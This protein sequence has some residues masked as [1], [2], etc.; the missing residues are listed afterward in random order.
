[1]RNILVV[2][3]EPLVRL[4]LKSISRWEE[5]GYTIK[6]EAENGKEALEIL[7]VEEIDIIICDINMPI[8][9]GLELIQEIKS[10]NLCDKIIVLSAY[11]EYNYLRAAF[12]LGVSDYILKNDMDFNHIVQILNG[13]FTNETDSKAVRDII[14]SKELHEKEY[15][16]ACLIKNEL[17]NINEN[18][19]NLLNLKSNNIILLNIIIEDF[20]SIEKK[21]R[22][23]GLDAFAYS[24]KNCLNQVLSKISYK[25]IV[26]LSPENYVI[27]ISFQSLSLGEIR[28][29][30]IQLISE[31]RYAMK[32]YINLYVSVVVSDIANKFSTIHKLFLECQEASYLRFIYEKDRTIFP[33]DR[34]IISMEGG[35]INYHKEKL[36][37]Q[38]NSMKFQDAMIT[39]NVLLSEA[40]LYLE[41]KT[42]EGIMPLY[43]QIIIVIIDFTYKQ[44]ESIASIFGIDVDFKEV[45]SR[46]KT[47]EEVTIWFNNMMQWLINYF[48][49]KNNINNNMDIIEDKIQSVC[50]FI[51]ENFKEELTLKIVSDYVGLSETYFSKIFTKKVGKSFIA[52]LTHVRVE[53]AK[54]LLKSSGLKIHEISEKVGFINV[55]HFSRVFKKVTGYSPNSFRDE[56]KS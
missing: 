45:L 25:E 53:K 11:N 21:Y 32:T 7:K 37:E 56:V 39:L 51:Q 1:M 23:R 31:I 27:L 42:I 14:P 49:S 50:S 6:G 33:E 41:K 44:Q 17:D 8:M 24:V 20:V 38:L 28:E 54:A 29:N 40:T 52:Y 48:V 35:N 12:R 13:I 26:S 19:L 36:S 18:Q 30:L 47:H 16:I 15:L 43:L 10:Q 3:D 2:D 9:N 4:A 5:Y 22:G 55:E 34:A 46:F